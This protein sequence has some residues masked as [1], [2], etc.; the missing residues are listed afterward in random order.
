[1]LVTFMT[2]CFGGDDSTTTTPV[3][4][5]LTIGGTV[6]DLATLASAALGAPQ[7]AVDY[8]K[9][10]AALVNATTKLDVATSSLSTTGAF[11]FG[12]KYTAFNA[13]IVI[14]ETA[15][16]K[17]LYTHLLGTLPTTTLKT[18]TA[19]V[20][21]KTTAQTLV[22]LANNIMPTIAAGTTATI[23]DSN[24]TTQL[25]SVVNDITNLTNAIKTTVL[26]YA[27]VTGTS[28]TNIALKLLPIATTTMQTV[29][30][31]FNTTLKQTDTKI[32]SAVATTFGSTVTPATATVT[33]GGQ[34]VQQTTTTVPVIVVPVTVTI[35]GVTN[36]ADINVANGVIQ[37]AIT[38]PTTVTVTKSDNTT[39]SAAVVWSTT[40]TPVAYNGTT[41]GTYTFTGTVTGTTLTASVNVIVAPAA[42]VTIA[43]FAT[44]ADKNVVN[45][46]ALTAVGLPTTV[47]ATMSDATTT[48]PAVIWDGGTPAYNATTAGTYVFKGT[49]TGTTLQPTVNVIVAAPGVAVVA[50][51]AAIADKNVANGTLLAALALPTTVTA[52]MSDATVT[53]PAVAWD[54]GTPAYNATTA[55]TYVFSGTVAGT[56]IKA[57]VNV[58][59][60]AAPV[61]GTPVL[62]TVVATSATTKDTL[63]LTFTNAGLLTAPAAD[64]TVTRTVDGLA[65]NFI[66]VFTPAISTTDSMSV[67]L[68]V[69]PV[70]T[71]GTA[72]KT[73]VYSVAYKTATAIAAASFSVAAVPAALSTV[74]VSVLSVE[75]TKT[76]AAVVVVKDNLG[77]TMASTAYTLAFASS[78]TNVFTVNATTGVITAGLY[79]SITK[80][81]TL[82]VTATPTAVGGVAKTGTA[83]IT[84]TPD[85]TKPTIVKAEAINNKTIIVTYNKKVADATS[86]S[87]VSALTQ[88]KYSLYNMTTGQTGTFVGAN[89]GAASEIYVTAAFTDSTNTAVKFIITGL[90]TAD[91]TGYPAGG[92]S[93]GNYVIYVK[94]VTDTAATPNVIVTNT[95]YQFTGTLAVDASGPGLASATLNTATKLLTM[96]FDKIAT[97]GD[98]TKITLTNGTTNLVLTASESK[99]SDNALSVT[100][101]V[102]NSASLATLATMTGSTWTI[103][104]GAGA[105]KDA[106]NNNNAAVTNATL[107]AVVP[108]ELSS[109]A[110]DE[111]T[112]VLTLTFSQTLKY[113]SLA[114][115]TSALTL[116]EGSNTVLTLDSNDTLT[117]TT[118]ANVYTVTPSSSHITSLEAAALDSKTMAVELV[119]N[120]FYSLENIGNIAT[121]ATT[122]KTL[123]VTQDT[124]KP[125]IVSASYV[126]STS[127]LTVTFNVNLETVVLGTV[128]SA[129]QIFSDQDNATKLN[130]GANATVAFD[131]TSKKTLVF[132]LSGANITAMY[133][134]YHAGYNPY[135]YVG[136]DTFVKEY[137]AQTLKNLA[138]TTKAAANTVAVT[139]DVK[140]TVSGSSPDRSTILLTFSEDVKKTTAEALTSGTTATYT[141]HAQGSA[142]NLTVYSATMTDANATTGLGKNVKVIVDQMAATTGYHIIVKNVEDKTGN[143]IDTT[144][145]NDLAADDFNFTSGATAVVPKVAKVII[146]DS[147][148]LNVLDGSDKIQVIFDRPVRLK[149]NASADSTTKLADIVGLYTATNK[150]ALANWNSTNVT[151][152]AKDVVTLHSTDENS[153][154]IS[155]NSKLFDTVASGANPTDITVGT[156][157]LDVISGQTF[158]VY[159]NST[160]DISADH[161]GAAVSAIHVITPPGDNP[162]VSTVK[163]ED[164]NNDGL[165]NTGDKFYVTF[166]KDVKLVAG[167]FDTGVLRLAKNTGAVDTE[168]FAE[169]FG[170]NATYT[171][172]MT[173]TV[174][175]NSVTV[176]LASDYAGTATASDIALTNMVA[177]FN[178]SAAVNAFYARALANKLKDTWGVV[179]GSTFAAGADVAAYVSQSGPQL[180][181]AMYFDADQSGSPTTGDT[182]MLEF[183]KTVAINGTAN[184]AA[185]NTAF[186]LGVAADFNTAV[187]KT[188]NRKQIVFTLAQNSVNIFYGSTY[189]NVKSTPGTVF[190]GIYGNEI[191]AAASN[192]K[193]DSVGDT[194]GPVVQ[195]AT[196]ISNNKVKV[197]FDEAITFVAGN[198]TSATQKWD[199]NEGGIATYVLKNYDA[200]AGAAGAVL[201]YNYA[202]QASVYTATVTNGQYG[203]IAKFDSTDTSNKTI[204]IT[205]N[206]GNLIDGTTSGVN[207]FQYAASNLVNTDDAATLHV[208]AGLFKD[209][210]GNKNLS[211][212]YNATSALDKSVKIKKDL[213]VPTVP[214]A[215]MLAQI[216]FNFATG[217]VNFGTINMPDG[218]AP[219][220]S[221]GK[222]KFEVY[223]GSL[224]PGASTSPSGASAFQN[225]FSSSDDFVV[226]T[227]GIVAGQAVW[228]RI[229]DVAANSSAW[230]Q[231]GTVPAAPDATK[232]S[233]SARSTNTTTLAGVSTL[234]STSAVLAQ[235]EAADAI[236]TTPVAKGTLTGVNL[237]TNASATAIAGQGIANPKFVLYTVKDAEGN[238][239]AYTSDGAVPATPTVAN[240]AVRY[241]ATATAG[242]KLM[243]ISGGALALT[244]SDTFTLYINNAVTTAT[245][246]GNAA[247]SAVSTNNVNATYVAAAAGQAL[248][249]TA[250]SS[251]GVESAAS[252]QGAVTVLK[253]ATAANGSGVATAYDANDTVTLAFDAGGAVNVDVLTALVSTDLPSV[254]I[255]YGATATFLIGGA[256]TGTNNANVVVTI[257]GAGLALSG[258]QATNVVNLLANQNKI[259]TATGKNAVL[260]AA[261]GVGNAALTTG[262]TAANF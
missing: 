151:D 36:P 134:I 139:D 240:F 206:N 231:D 144:L 66:P 168:S 91:L 59:V 113:S 118:N 218:A 157:M 78:D 33:V 25:A 119:A 19:T 200:S 62:S 238:V 81:A 110:Y 121:T 198:A 112:N 124:T 32:T 71:A 30:D 96:N 57:T 117:P 166:N 5:D 249:V 73:V 261:A 128:G 183:D 85:A 252:N 146:V 130:M 34:T 10:Q 13:M 107:T 156:D 137:S 208:E 38:F 258:T 230:V 169:A 98:M 241:E 3:A 248:G 221:E 69:T 257:V 105:V 224:T 68:E 103:S 259:V 153:I 95:N 88:G 29:L 61:A 177:P 8:T 214:D 140:P 199:D 150:T 251:T 185:L 82:T 108:P 87:Y 217:K 229:T 233:Y 170:A 39:A 216:G 246:A 212:A 232:L 210:Y 204:I 89:T 45:G 93:T 235:W 99:T 37:S 80:T 75:E 6:P 225:V 122:V 142:T 115:L 172:T 76:T 175:A 152:L 237:S 51:I 106:S 18:I 243:N 31:A 222:V 190:T 253:S 54:G 129:I 181:K 147:G 35:T 188:D 41:A 254:G 50:S 20:T 48:T 127:K 191:V 44:I 223:V 179:M 194:T 234:T 7:R 213:T 158:V 86:G 173:T 180:V 53:T 90:D 83:V 245:L 23:T 143:K 42:T 111:T 207:G 242:Y 14:R 64:F 101:T 65:D 52:T 155:V 178:T 209:V 239:S 1:M 92:L 176:T 94:D 55:G 12:I 256:A 149:T 202:S 43:S 74:E 250:T 104:L 203:T 16:A 72:A 244:A 141:V 102:A 189:V 227:T 186:T 40:S 160:T 120:K 60:A 154:L 84:I 58:I 205:L 100:I 184:G 136:A 79:N 255:N 193:L 182:I 15:T 131:P 63:V 163:Y 4:T 220:V 21:A 228:Y 116:K 56:T 262:M 167:T 148:S 47:T 247:A 24:L 77:A 211:Y 11:S 162:K 49:V 174:A 201:A 46:T 97:I 67:T 195:S 260:P 138:V 22:A 187:V 125:A 9:Y 135:L 126:E 165:I 114:I 226:N 197:V 109:A 26:A 17:V 145:P 215:T 132:T 70:V 171:T 28:Q 236:G 161:A 2:G 27:N 164:V 196:W 219:K 159:K 192:V 133:N 123:A